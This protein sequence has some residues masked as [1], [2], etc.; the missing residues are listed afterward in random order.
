MSPTGRSGS[1]EQYRQAER[2]GTGAIPPAFPDTTQD[3]DLFVQKTA[4][5]CGKIGPAFDK[6]ATNRQK[7]R[8]SLTRLL[9]FRDW[10]GKNPPI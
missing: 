1:M 3:A 4:S 6:E 9:Q 10:L 8:E 5:N 7:D 2:S